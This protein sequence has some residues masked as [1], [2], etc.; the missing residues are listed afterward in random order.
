MFNYR[1]ILHVCTTLAL[2]LFVSFLEQTPSWRAESSFTVSSRS[3]GSEETTPSRVQ[4][5]TAAFW[6]VFRNEEQW[7]WILQ[8]PLRISICLWELK[9]VHIDNIK[10]CTL[11][12]LALLVYDVFLVFIAPSLTRFGESTMEMIGLG[13]FDSAH[14]KKIP[15]LLRFHCG[16]LHQDLTELLLS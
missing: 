15:L 14:H 11:F 2:Q 4:K 6:M 7:A 5:L 3:L 8:D 16:T 1:I 9:K 10:N 12:L 13:P